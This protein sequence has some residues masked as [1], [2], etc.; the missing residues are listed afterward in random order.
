[1]CQSALLALQGPVE[2]SDD[3]DD[4]DE[5]KPPPQDEEHLQKFHLVITRFRK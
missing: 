5:Q 3:G 4:G 2:Q 1:M